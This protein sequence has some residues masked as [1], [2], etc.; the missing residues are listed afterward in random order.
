MDHGPGNYKATC[1]RDVYQ[2]RATCIRGNLYQ[3]HAS[4]RAL[5]PQRIPTTLNA[6]QEMKFRARLGNLVISAVKYVFAPDV[7]FDALDFSERVLV[8]IIVFRNHILF[9]PLA[10]GSSFS[11]DLDRIKTEVMFPSN[12]NCDIPQ[13]L[14]WFR[15]TI[16]IVTMFATSP[17]FSNSFAE[18]LAY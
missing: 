17:Y 9:D 18:S 12:D 5:N 11:I 4:F 14:K 10:Q 16:V 2:R 8:P 7:Q 1:I 3:R 6:A 15:Q 13:L